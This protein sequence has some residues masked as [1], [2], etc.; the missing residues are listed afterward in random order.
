METIKINTMVKKDGHIVID[1]PTNYNECEVEL[2][3]IMNKLLKIKEK[4]RYD[5]SK[6]AN[7]LSWRGNAVLEQRNLRD[8]WY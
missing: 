1:I 3:V 5:F 4:K 2:V 7:K 6:F 8:E